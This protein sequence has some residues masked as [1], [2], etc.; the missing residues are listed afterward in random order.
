MHNKMH[1]YSYQKLKIGETNKLTTNYNKSTRCD[2]VTVRV[3]INITDN[4]VI[5]IY[6]KN[7]TTSYTSK[8]NFTYS[9]LPQVQIY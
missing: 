5:Y 2:T 6:F 7:I 9:I 3:L 4:Y 8:Y 1:I